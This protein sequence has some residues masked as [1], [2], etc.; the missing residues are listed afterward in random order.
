MNN[1]VKLSEREQKCLAVLVDYV[2]GEEERCVYMKT[3]AE[4]TK[5]T[6][7][8][9]RRSVRALARKGLAKY[10]RGLFDEDGK[11]AGSGYCASEEG[12]QFI[13]KWE[14]ELRLEELERESQ[15]TLI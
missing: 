10:H 11:V 15:Q 3:I 9:V 1:E 12:T 7:V 4:E 5:L 6:L 2:N 8:Q 13:E 14:E